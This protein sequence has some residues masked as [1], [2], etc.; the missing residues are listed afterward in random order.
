MPLLMEMKIMKE[1]R[2]TLIIP[3]FTSGKHSKRFLFHHDLPIA[4]E[5]D[6]L[7]FLFIAGFTCCL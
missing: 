3:P 1:A 6:W 7:A 4:I 5:K 2:C